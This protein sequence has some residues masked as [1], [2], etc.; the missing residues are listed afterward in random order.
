MKRKTLKTL[1]YKSNRY[2]NNEAEIGKQKSKLRTYTGCHFQ[3]Q[4]VKIDNSF[5]NLF[6]E[7]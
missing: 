3:K 5:K 2:K 6:T 4:K 1:F 7:E